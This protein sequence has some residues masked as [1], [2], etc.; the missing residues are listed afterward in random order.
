MPQAGEPNPS[1]KNHAHLNGIAMHKVCPNTNSEL[2]L[3]GAAVAQAVAHTALINSAALQSHST[4]SCRMPSSVL[5]IDSW[6]PLSLVDKLTVTSPHTAAYLA[7]GAICV[8]HSCAASSADVQ[9]LAAAAADAA[10]INDGGI[11]AGTRA[12]QRRA[13]STAAARGIYQS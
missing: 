6:K 3:Q 13:F 8:Q 1:V 11:T 10:C 9:E 4:E 2:K 5:P 12:V 7:A